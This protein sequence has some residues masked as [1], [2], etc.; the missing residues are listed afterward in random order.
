MHA[1]A[2]KKWESDNDLRRV[3]AKAKIDALGNPQR[4]FL[5]QPGDGSSIGEQISDLHSYLS[6][7]EFTMGHAE[8]IRGYWVRCAEAEAAKIKAGHD[9]LAAKASLIQVG[10]EHPLIGFYSN[11]D[12]ADTYGYGWFWDTLIIRSDGTWKHTPWSET[13]DTQGESGRKTS[14]LWQSGLRRRCSILPDTT[15]R[16]RHFRGFSCRLSQCRWHYCDWV[17]S[18]VGNQVGKEMSGSFT[19]GRPSCLIVATGDDLVR[20]REAQR[21]GSCYLEVSLALQAWTLGVTW[22]VTWCYLWCYLVLLGVTWA[23]LGVT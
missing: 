11:L 15:R 2:A 1:D 4:V 3:E 6:N 21:V 23:L 20:E 19:R 10:A 17:P 9:R 13:Q 12:G 5:R 8:W 18:D 7:G 22:S 14:G 16:A